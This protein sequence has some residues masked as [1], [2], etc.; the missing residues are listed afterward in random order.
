MVI[1]TRCGPDGHGVT[2]DDILS[3]ERMP[4]DNDEL[5]IG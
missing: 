5:D 1:V 3:I 4:A 2:V